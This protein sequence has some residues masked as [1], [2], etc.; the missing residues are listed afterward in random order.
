MTTKSKFF[1]RNLVTLIGSTIVD[2][3]GSSTIAT[4]SNVNYPITNLKIQ[5]T[6]KQFRTKTGTL[7]CTFVIDCGSPMAASDVL[8]VGDS[9]TGALYVSS[10]TIKGAANNSASNWTAATAY[11]FSGTSFVDETEFFAHGSFPEATFRYWQVTVTNPTGYVGF[12]NIFIGTSLEMPLSLDN[13]MTRTD[14]SV[15][16]EG[17]YGQKYID[18]LP[19][20][21]QF[22]FSLEYQTKEER[23]EFDAMFDYCGIKY[24][25]WF[26]MDPNETVIYNKEVTAGYCYLDS[27]PTWT[28]PFVGLYSTSFNLSQVI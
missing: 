4:F 1:Y 2:S 17:R 24:P 20:Q 12:S 22:G 27:M 19:Y 26:I 16:Q 6:T 9:V 18:I 14:R 15:V 23:E 8:L 11:T 7:T 5:T 28:T 10:V 3:D 21:K 25:L 13:T